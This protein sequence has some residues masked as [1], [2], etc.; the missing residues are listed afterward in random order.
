MSTIRVTCL[1]CEH[2]VEVPATQ[3]VLHQGGS[4]RGATDQYGFSCPTCSVYVVRHA[5]RA[6]VQALLST[7]VQIATGAL[8]PWE[9]GERPGI[10]LVDAGATSEQRACVAAPPITEADVLLFRKALDDDAILAAWLAS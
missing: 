5:T 2:P 6:V 1:L 8:P 4:G 10:V 3:V 9:I 7:D